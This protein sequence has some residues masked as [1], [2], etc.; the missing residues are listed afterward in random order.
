MLETNVAV[1]VR[2]TV[3]EEEGM[4]ERNKKKE[5]KT[6]SFFMAAPCY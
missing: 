6:H 1:H 4:S 5:R 3:R 2:M